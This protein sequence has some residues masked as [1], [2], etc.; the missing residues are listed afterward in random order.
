[1]LF[2]ESVMTAVSPPKKRRRHLRH[3]EKK[4]EFVL[5]IKEK[6][7]KAKSVRYS[8]CIIGV[9]DALPLPK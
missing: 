3:L 1:M 6:N 7:K 5:F 4:K 2:A 9:A 8:V